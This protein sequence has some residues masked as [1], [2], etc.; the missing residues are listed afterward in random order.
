[1][2]YHFKIHR[3]K[4]G[5]WAECLELDGCITQADNREEL[6][7]NCEEAL[8]LFLEEPADSKII[9]PLP[10]D[11]LE[12]EKDIM[13]VQVEP[14]I[15]LAVLLRNYRLNSNMTQKQVAEMLGM[16]NIYSYQ[17]LEKKSNPTLAIINKIHTIFP[18]IELN[19]LLQ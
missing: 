4:T 2:K 13:K 17:R 15:A 10:D 18:E 16:K 1:M 9:F 3:E 8:N 5:F 14:E 11:S 7:K 19:Y 12:G 6:Y